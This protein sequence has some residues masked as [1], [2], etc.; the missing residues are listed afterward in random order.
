MSWVQYNHQ[1]D[2][3][4]TSSCSTYTNLSWILDSVLKSSVA[5]YLSTQWLKNL[6]MHKSWKIKILLLIRMHKLV[7]NKKCELRNIESM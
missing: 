5:F 7:K 3:T 2:S 1:Q 4:L 6:K